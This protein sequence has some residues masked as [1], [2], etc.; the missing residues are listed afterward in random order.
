MAQEPEESAEDLYDSAPC[1]YLTLRPDGTIVR[2]NRTFLDW[3]GY[4]REELTGRRVQEIYA[5]GSRIFH[6]THLA[7]LLHIQGEVREIAAEFR[8]ADGTR[9]D[10]LVNALLREGPAGGPATVRMTVFDAT[11]RRTY[12][13][14]LLAERRLAE[15]NA[16]RVRLLQ[17]LVVRCAAIERAE[18]IAGPIVQIGAEAFT[19]DRTRVWLLDPAEAALRPIGDGPLV[20]LDDPG[21]EARAAAQLDIARHT[22]V[23][24]TRII[25]PLLADLRVLGVVSFM[26]AAPEPAFDDEAVELMRTIG[27][28]AG[29]ALDRI[30]LL[31]ETTRRAWQSGFLARLSRDLDETVGC[32]GRARR[33]VELLVPDVAEYAQ[34]DLAPAD[35]PAWRAAAPE[36]GRDA[37]GWTIPNDVLAAVHAAGRGGVMAAVP[38]ISTDGRRA[39]V[40]PLRA[41]NTVHGTLLLAVGDVA[42]AGHVGPEFLA[43]LADRAG[44]SLDNARLAERDREVAHTLQRSLLAGEW[45]KD[46]RYRVV[47]AYRPAVHTLEVGG[48]W[49]DV[50]ATSAESIGIVVGDVVGRG[51]RAASAMGQ[52]RSAVRALATAN[53]G[54]ADVL[55]HMDDFVASFS[56]GQMTT[57]A[58]AEL[59]LDSGRLR[60]A[61]AGHP[62]PLLVEPGGVPSF[63]W[64]ARSGPLGAMAAGRARS[65]AALT[66]PRGSRLVLYTDGLVERRGEPTR[67]RLDRLAGLAA[68]HWQEP[69]ST[70]AGRLSDGMLPGEGGH[71][72]MCLLALDYTD[73][74][75]F[76]AEVPARMSELAGMRAALDRWLGAQG[77]GD[78]DRFGIVLATAEAVANAIEHGYALDASRKVSVLAQVDGDVVAIRVAD[79]GQWRPPRSALQRGRGLALIGRLMEDLVID[80]G[81]GTTVLMRRRAGDPSRRRLT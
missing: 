29:Q 19:A 64:G 53:D 44:L 79:A 56:A 65:E 63:L 50:F 54:P 59:A 52:L 1:G 80:R 7:P 9:L 60:Y 47:T 46:A 36:D 23:D 34:I 71:D 25:A 5:A 70:L 45:P 81:S 75:P 13:R 27:R 38:L 76:R 33:L 58:Y 17:E 31:E 3:M 72:D 41:R 73:A 26:F 6:E 30:R 66:V 55:R 62:P 74:P 42:A 32:T 11:T 10:A 77:I 43:D 57:L 22:D 15:R 48:D 21:P 39:L 24:G 78:Y 4:G 2:V 67:Q 8:R 18:Q 49:Y 28:Q 16:T 14:E 20:S 35:E 68:A 40:L 51:L 37:A 69:L 12:E 61:C